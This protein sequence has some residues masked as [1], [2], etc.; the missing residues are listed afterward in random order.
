[1]KNE[2]IN[3]GGLQ[4]EE[5]AFRYATTKGDIYFNQLWSRVMPFS[6]K[7][8]NKYPSIEYEDKI[9]IA[10][11]CL[12]DCCNNLKEGQNVLTLYGRI[13]GNRLYDLWGK[14]MQTGKY[15]INSEAAS[16]EKMQEDVNYEPSTS[17]D[18]FS[19][20]LFYSDCKFANIEAMMVEL[21]YQG[22]NKCEI[23]ARL[24][25][26]S[27]DYSQLLENIKNKIRNNY[28]EESNGLSI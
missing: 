22:Y 12:M 20:N 15:K 25:L 9:S 26:K 8:S 7:I 11:E 14:S 16:L 6:I 17:I 13:L 4:L 24:K 18:E 28:L 23:K 19:L 3:N 2:I 10:M 21:I 1:M 5:L 27:E